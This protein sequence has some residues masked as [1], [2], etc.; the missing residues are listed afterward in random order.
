MDL[1]SDFPKQTPNTDFAIRA[2][3]PEPSPL[4]TENAN[5]SRKVHS[6]I[7]QNG[8]NVGE[9]SPKV[10]SYAVVAAGSDDSPGRLTQIPPANEGSIH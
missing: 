4:P 9:N 3:D 5:S 1:K 6:K 2:G 10:R 7:P 8:E